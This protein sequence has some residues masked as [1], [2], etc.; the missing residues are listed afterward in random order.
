MC[1]VTRAVHQFLDREGPVLTF[2]SRKGIFRLN[3]VLLQPAIDMTAPVAKK[4]VR[5][6]GPEIDRTVP[7]LVIAVRAN[8][9]EFVSPVTVGDFDEA[10]AQE[11]F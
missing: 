6:T 10:L 5:Q 2:I 11:L 9:A 1:P 7:G 4:T 8:D 3:P